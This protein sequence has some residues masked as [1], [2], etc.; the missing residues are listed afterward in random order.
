MP[1]G[2]LDALGE[3]GRAQALQGRRLV[4]GVGEPTVDG[5]ARQWKSAAS[6]CR[7]SRRY[8][9]PAPRQAG[10]SRLRSPGAAERC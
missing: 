7:S 5:A 1:S 2:R 3:R 4:A 9:S 10:A 6:P 8:V